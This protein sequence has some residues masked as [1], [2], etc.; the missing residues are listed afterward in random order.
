MFTKIT[1]LSITPPAL[2]GMAC[3]RQ[4]QQKQ[5]DWV[6]KKRIMYTANICITVMS[7]SPSIFYCTVHAQSVCMHK[8][9]SC[10]QSQLCRRSYWTRHFLQLTTHVGCSGKLR[11][12]CMGSGALSGKFGQ[13]H[14][15]W[16]YIHMQYP[17]LVNYTKLGFIQIGYSNP[18][19]LI[20]YNGWVP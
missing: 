1:F 4:S 13:E 18:K 3:I 5:L 16:L 8:V 15:L 9:C 6:G 7:S 10:I 17:Q 19:S 20:L 2:M 14:C 12:W 11:T